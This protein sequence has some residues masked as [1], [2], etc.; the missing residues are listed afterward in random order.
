MLPVGDNIEGEYSCSFIET[1]EE[2]KPNDLS[3]AAAESDTLSLQ[4]KV[5]KF[6]QHGELDTIEGK[7]WMHKEIAW[8]L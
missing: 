7:L 1:V 4:E 5:A 6:V 3:S 8:S 2:F